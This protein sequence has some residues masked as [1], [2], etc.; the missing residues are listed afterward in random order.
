MAR[1]TENRGT[2]QSD[3]TLLRIL[4]ALEEREGAGVTELADHLGIAKSTVHNH[5]STLHDAGFVTK[6]DGEYNLGLRFLD[7]GE[8]ARRQWEGT[9]LIDEKV[10]MLA[11]ET[12]ERVQFIV[13]EHGKG[14]F[15]YRATGSQAVPTDTH[16]GKRIPLNA[17]ASG[18]AILANLPDDRVREIAENG[19]FERR[20]EQTTTEYEELRP[21]LDR[22]RERGYAVNRE[23]TTD[24][25]YA[26]GA[27]VHRPDGSVLGALSVSGPAHRFKGRRFE[28]EIP[29]LILGAANE[30]ELNL[31]FS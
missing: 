15:L 10:T 24:G 14:T 8:S 28:E 27:P 1:Q 26:V 9:E 4:A 20:T 30:I 2:V 23:E 29:D 16:I 22:I 6:A 11:E 19:K 31:T 18:K 13:E 17:A 7:L 12:D 21:E 25:L 5:L 3:L